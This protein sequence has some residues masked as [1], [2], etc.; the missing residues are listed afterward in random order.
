[1]KVQ[2]FDFELIKLKEASTGYY[3]LQIAGKHSDFVEITVNTVN[4]KVQF[5]DFSAFRMNDGKVLIAIHLINKVFADYSLTAT[6][7][8]GNTEI[9][10]TQTYERLYQYYD[11]QASENKGFFIFEN[12]VPVPPDGYG[13]RCDNNRFGPQFFMKNDVEYDPLFADLSEIIV[14][15]PVLSVSEV[16]HIIYVNGTRDAE[17]ED[18]HL[19]EYELPRAARTLHELFKLITEWAD[20]SL[21]P[22]N[23]EETIALKAQEFLQKINFSSEF[24]TDVKENQIDMQVVKYIKGDTNARA[25]SSFPAPLSLIADKELKKKVSHLSLSNLFSLFDNTVD[26]TASVTAFEDEIVSKR[27]NALIN[28]LQLSLEKF[29]TKDISTIVQAM[30]DKTQAQVR[31]PFLIYV[32]TLAVRREVLDNANANT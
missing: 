21:S 24:I 3:M 5:E 7:A 16:A 17:L 32:T 10:N 20:T 29:T 18:F 4:G 6:D 9:I 31:P 15:E 25:R 2:L 28:E 26:D 11:L 14:Y 8:L 23:N 13:W 19:E 27:Q 12:S 30:Q 1:M 22:W